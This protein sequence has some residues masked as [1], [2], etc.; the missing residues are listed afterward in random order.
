MIAVLGVDPCPEAVSMRAGLRGRA[1][2][3]IGLFLI[4]LGARVAAK[5][6]DVGKH[7]KPSE[8]DTEIIRNLRAENKELRKKLQALEAKLKEVLAHVKD[9]ELTRWVKKLKK[10]RRTSELAA[11]LAR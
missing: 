9:P 8:L 6:P 11:I 10:Q 4:L 1:L 3:R 7:E 2:W 5:E